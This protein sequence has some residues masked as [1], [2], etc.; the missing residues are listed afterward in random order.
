MH[1]FALLGL[2]KQ[3]CNHPALVEGSVKDYGR[4]ASGKWDLF[5]E[6]LSE[7]LDSGQKVVV[8]SQYLGML[9]IMEAHIAGLDIEYAKLTGSSRN[10][11]DI[12][13]RFNNDPR[14]R[15]FLGSLK[16][17]GIGIDLVAA[18]VVIHYDRWWN[19]A[20]EDQATDRVH[21]IGQRGSPRL[22]A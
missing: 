8:Y 5:T 19:A 11:G 21:R 1:I 16:A 3:I 7:S 13:D 14:C 9:D 4:Y 20:R 22:P 18:S 6:L 10:R 2:L 12:I 15:V 17:G